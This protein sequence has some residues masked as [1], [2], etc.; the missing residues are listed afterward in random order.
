MAGA[1]PN[2]AADLKLVD[3]FDLIADEGIV[4][5]LG[6]TS[7]SYLEEDVGTPAAPIPV[8]VVAAVTRLLPPNALPPRHA[9]AAQAQVD[10]ELLP[11]E[12]LA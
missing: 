11:N 7:L 5:I 2:L 4:A 1:R 6:T 10:N 12:P 8:E 3:A 9:A